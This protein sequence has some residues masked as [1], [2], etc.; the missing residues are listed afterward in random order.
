MGAVPSKRPTS[1][2]ELLQAINRYCAATG[3]APSLLGRSAI[4]DPAL[5]HG[6][7]MDGNRVSGP[8]TACF[9]TSPEPRTT[10]TMTPPTMPA[11]RRTPPRPAGCVQLLAHIESHYH[12]TG[13]S[14]STF[15]RLAADDSML[16]PTL[17]R[18]RE[19]RQAT[20]VRIMAFIEQGAGL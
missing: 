5:V 12:R 13:L 2:S 4:G 20:R 7:R 19:P 8:S 11:I 9:P 14:F 16:V 1:G 15:G 10:A 18:G 17:N 6:L 3:V